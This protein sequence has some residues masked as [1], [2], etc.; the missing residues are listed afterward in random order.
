MSVKLPDAERVYTDLVARLK[1]AVTDATVMVGIQ[2]GGAWVAE[3]LHRDLAIAAPLGILNISFYRDDYS[4]SGLHSNVRPS[5]IPFDVSGKRILLVEMSTGQMND[6]VNLATK[7]SKKLE[8]FGKTGGVVPTPDEVLEKLQ[9]Y[10][11]KKK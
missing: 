10:S 8:F 4:S 11:G 5:Q 9:N 7:S 1:P 3:R 6:D 2:T